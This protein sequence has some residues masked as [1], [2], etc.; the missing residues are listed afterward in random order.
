V[1]RGLGK[2]NPDSKEAKSP[3]MVPT[4]PAKDIKRLVSRIGHGRLKRSVVV[5]DFLGGLITSY[6]KA[7][8]SKALSHPLFDNRKSDTLRSAKLVASVLKMIMAFSSRPVH[9]VAVH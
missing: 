7:C 6:T 1:R 2:A 3:L 8:S 4:V 5:S 9:N